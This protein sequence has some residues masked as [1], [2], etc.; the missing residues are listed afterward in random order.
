MS[1]RTRGND[2]ENPNTPCY[3]VM[4]FKQTIIHLICVLRQEDH[5][6][7]AFRRT[8]NKIVSGLISAVAIIY[9]VH[10]SDLFSFFL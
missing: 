9:M 1:C 4:I 2:D 6:D 5:D 8:H 7:H 3:F 10:I